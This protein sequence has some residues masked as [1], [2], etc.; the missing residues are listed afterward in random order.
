MEW[1]L[2]SVRTANPE[3]LL[4]YAHPKQHDELTALFGKERNVVCIPTRL[5]YLSIKTKSDKEQPDRI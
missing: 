5:Y 2:K 3:N 1:T 4:I